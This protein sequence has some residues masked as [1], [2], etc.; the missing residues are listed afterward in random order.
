MT[1]K[2]NTVKEIYKNIKIL[3]MLL[4]YYRHAVG[5]LLFVG[6]TVVYYQISAYICQVSVA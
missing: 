5:F 3:K 4:L 1:T 6:F 2:H